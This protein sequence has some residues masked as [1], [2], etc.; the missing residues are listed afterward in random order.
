MKLLDQN[1]SISSYEMEEEKKEESPSISISEN[2]FSYK[3]VKP[4]GKKI[5]GCFSSCYDY[6]DS[7]EENEKSSEA[8]KQKSPVKPYGLFG[9]KTFEEVVS[10][11]KEKSEH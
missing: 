7:D 10:E 3:I 1:M 8:E 9:Y 6:S 5:F 4:K 2:T 11:M